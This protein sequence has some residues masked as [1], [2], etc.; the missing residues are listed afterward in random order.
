[1]KEHYTEAEAVQMVRNGV[2]DLLKQAG[3]SDDSSVRHQLAMMNF[4]E[5]DHV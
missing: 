5:V 1:M 3:Y 2:D 4:Y